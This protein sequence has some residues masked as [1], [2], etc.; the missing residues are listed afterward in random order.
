MVKSWSALVPATATSPAPNAATGQA[1]A[2]TT[3]SLSRSI[4][5]G[6][7]SVAHASRSISRTYEPIDSGTP[8]RQ[9]TGSAAPR[10][11]QQHAAD[12]ERPDRGRG[13]RARR[14]HQGAAVAPRRREHAGRERR[15]PRPDRLAGEECA[16]IALQRFDAR[17]AQVRVLLQAGVDD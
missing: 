12:A 8:C 10:L 16:Q 14:D 4:V 9:W 11:A 2:R 5:T 6:M 13:D 17:I 3:V 1:G 7:R 15:P